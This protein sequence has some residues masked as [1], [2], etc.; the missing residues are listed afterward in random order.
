MRPVSLSSAVIFDMDG[1]LVDSEPL[2]IRAY[3]QAAPSSEFR[4]SPLPRGNLPGN[5]KS[6]RGQCAGLGSQTVR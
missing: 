5:R 2:Q 1:V 3:V 6:H 4:H